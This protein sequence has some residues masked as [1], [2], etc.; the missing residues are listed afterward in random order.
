MIR[1]LLSLVVG[2][3]V[4]VMLVI[5]LVIFFIVQMTHGGF[6]T[7][8][9]PIGVNPMPPFT[10]AVPATPAPTP[11]PV[12]DT[13]GTVPPASA[14]AASVPVVAPPAPPAGAAS[15]AA[16]AATSGT[17]E[18]SGTTCVVMETS[19]VAEFSAGPPVTGHCSVYDPQ[20]P[21]ATV[22]PEE[23]PETGT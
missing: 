23:L 14:A 6:A 2:L 12:S 9:H 10:A 5:A 19:P 4:F 21:G 16:P 18:P 13:P 3:V 7:T 22:V 1:S 8:T 15:P 11:P 17:P 20:Y